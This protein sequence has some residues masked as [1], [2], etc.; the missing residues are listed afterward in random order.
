VLAAQ[1]KKPQ[2]EAAFEQAIEV[3]HRCGLRLYEMFA[4]R[5]LKQCVLD[6]DGRGEDGVQRLKAVLKEMKGPAAE[7]T[8]LL[9]G[10]LDAAEVLCS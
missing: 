9:G 8:K 6:G 10:G 7:L 4:V 5:D 2:A 1:G 3:S